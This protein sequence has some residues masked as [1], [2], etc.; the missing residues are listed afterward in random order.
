MKDLFIRLANLVGET[1]VYHALFPDRI[2]VFMLHRITNGS[3]VS[4][5]A[6]PAE[7]LR[8][9]LKYLADRNYRVLTMDELLAVLGTNEGIPRKSVL[10]TIDDG[11]HDQFELAASIFDE[12]GF[13]LNFFVITDL[14]DGRLW[15]W[16]DQINY[17]ID[18]TKVTSAE[19]YLPSGNPHQIELASGT[20][21]Q[22][23]RKLKNLLK[24]EKQEHIY[25]WLQSELYRKLNVD[26]PP[27][28]PPEYRPMSWDNARSLRARGHGIYPHTC[29][30]RILSK[31]PFEQKQLEI[32]RSLQRV[33]SE[34]MFAP[35][36]FAYP[37]G[38]PND[39][40]STDIE[41]LRES[42]IQMAFNTVPDY[43]RKGQGMYELSRFSLPQ[44]DSEYRRIVNRL[45]ALSHV[46]VRHPESRLSF[47][48]IR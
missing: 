40:D 21:R 35:K 19:I 4:P 8:K 39:Y 48:P 25:E 12:F 38:R 27:A 45:E 5:G 11:F 33:E 15:P 3:T 1:G 6:M 26:F 43:I 30:H 10:F 36:V 47:L 17:V 20:A 14:L 9:Y 44:E 34:L 22:Q 31:L 13:P 29:S 18:H 7:T 32:Q 28:I 23:K 46:I 16:D 37:T 42:G 24:Q 2:P 41:V